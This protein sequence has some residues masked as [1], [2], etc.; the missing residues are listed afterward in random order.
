MSNRLSRFWQELKRR[1]VVRVITVYAASAFVVLEL[2]DIITDPFGLPDWTL[3]LVVVLLAVG[4]I[5]A[6]ILSWIYDIHPEDGIVKTEPVSKLRSEEVPRSSNSW[7]IASYI[8]FVVITGLII[9]NL[10]TRKGLENKDQPVGMS[11]AV[12]PFEDM[13]PEQ[14]QEYFCD[15]ISEEIINSLAQVPELKVIARTSSFSYKDR[16]QDIRE[17][18]LALGVE[19]IVEGSVQKIGDQLRIM[20]QLIHAEDGIHLWSKRFDRKFT[21]LFAIQDEISRSIVE[22]LKLELLGSQATSTQG[23][24]G[25]LEAYQLYLQGRHFWHR[26]TKQDLRQSMKYYRE[27][28]NLDSNY[29]LAYAGLA[30]AYF[31]SAYWR[32]MNYQEAY[33]SGKEFALKAISLDPNIPEAYATLGGIATWY[34]WDWKD[35][36]DL[37]LKALHL[38][39]NYASG[40]QYYSELQNI[41]GDYS[42]ARTNIDKAIALNPNSTVMYALSSN[43]YY[44][45]GDF[46]KA[47]EDDTKSY[48]LAL[49]NRPR[50]RAIRCLVRLQKYEDAL[51]EMNTMLTRIP[52]Y[53]PDKDLDSIYLAAGIRTAVRGFINEMEKDAYRNFFSMSSP[54]ISMASIY[55]VIDDTAMALEHIE[56]AYQYREA[57]VLEIYKGLDFR[58]L[59]E[60]P[61]YQELLALMN[62]ND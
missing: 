25:N 30:D 51:L 59:N 12:L 53:Q 1:N 32:Y 61:R 3:K 5:V 49:F 57:N 44:D 29:A 50:L 31:I 43:Y 10:L 16:N 9:L 62:L 2:V 33:E 13:S 11:I 38:N 34:D 7:K 6:V 26:R 28:I 42:G 47:L 45:T 35:A 15:G 21:D 17:I 22:N 8:S 40:Y 52:G 56:K 37:I 60:N 18:A 36:E 55:A 20:V 58:I 41:L 4:L 39:P 23:Q 19:T 48:E 27:A 54:N 46:D 14:D 24:T